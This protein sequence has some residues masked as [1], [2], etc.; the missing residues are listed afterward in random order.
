MKLETIRTVDD[1]LALRD[2]W[3]SLLESSA[4]SCVFLTH[5]WLS[6]WWKHLAGNRKLSILTL[7]DGGHLIGIL[8]VAE[9]PAQFARMMPR[10]LE[11]LGRSE[12]HTS[13]LQS[14]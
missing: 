7:R 5:E 9:R 8:P 14:H 3:N 6:T 13:E 4:S 2:E 1:F 12:E 11:F 10:A